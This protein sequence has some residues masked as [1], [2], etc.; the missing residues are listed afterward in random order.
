MV[1]P[2]KKELDLEFDHAVARVEKVLVEEGFVHMMTKHMDRVIMEKL[3]LSHY[4]RYTIILACG[5]ELAR[6]ALE[7]SRDTGLL[8]PCSFAVY[9]EEDKV[10]VG[11]VSIMKIAPAIG[12]APADKMG[13]VIEMTGSLVQA[14][15]QKI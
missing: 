12:L 2:I 1:E 5:P 8:F 4:P 15:W 11:H 7:V 6:A 9:Q 3:G 13:P 10:M 14:V